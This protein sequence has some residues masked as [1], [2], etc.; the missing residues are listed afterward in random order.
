MQLIFKKMKKGFTLIELLVVIAMIGIIA[1]IVV[2][3]VNDARVKSQDKAVMADLVALRSASQLWQEQQNGSYAGFCVNDC[4]SGGS[5]DWKRICAGIKLNNG[6][7]NPSCN[8]TAVAWCVASALI[9]GGT[10]CVD[11]TNHNQNGSC[12]GVGNLTCQ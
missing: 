3:N 9:S 5:D 12:G 8:N 11:S 10:Y 4:A 1:V 6:G 7:L 2:T